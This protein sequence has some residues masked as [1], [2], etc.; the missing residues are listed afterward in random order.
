MCIVTE[1]ISI[2]EEPPA[3]DFAPVPSDRE[4]RAQTHH[5]HSCRH[6]GVLGKP[7]EARIC[8]AGGQS[9]LN[10]PEAIRR[11]PRRMKRRTSVRIDCEQVVGNAEIKKLLMS[12]FVY[13]RLSYV[14]ARATTLH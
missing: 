10:R 8:V 7:G 14:D 3:D 5:P 12:S 9:R 11:C 4:Q 1:A 2:V 6:A 13:Q